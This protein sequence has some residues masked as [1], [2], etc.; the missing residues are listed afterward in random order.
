M[1][2]QNLET[3][4]RIEVKR[5]FVCSNLTKDLIGL[6]GEEFISGFSSIASQ[7]KTMSE[8]S[9]DDS[10]RADPARLSRYNLLKW[11]RHA[12][13]ITKLGMWMEARKLP[14][15]WCVGSLYQTA[16]KVEEAIEMGSLSTIAPQVESS[17]EGIRKVTDFIRNQ[18]LLYVIAVPPYCAGRPPYLGVDLGLDDGNMR[19]L[20]FAIIGY[21]KIL[22]YVGR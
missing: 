20:T 1:L 5:C 2:S 15:K 6:H 18:P 7:V 3:V 11:S 8:D 12:V 13:P 14:A 9:L 16:I 4:D 19:A 21:S 17:I 10:I 22:A